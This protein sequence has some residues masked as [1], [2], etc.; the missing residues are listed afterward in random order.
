[1]SAPPCG[2]PTDI[3]ATNPRGFNA[4]GKELLTNAGWTAPRVFG[5]ER[6]ICGTAR[7]TPTQPGGQRLREA[8]GVPHVNT[9]PRRA[10]AVNRS[11]QLV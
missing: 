4:P 6:A 9:P 10:R 11:G 7:D 3:Q 1:M 5:F 8:S 2:R